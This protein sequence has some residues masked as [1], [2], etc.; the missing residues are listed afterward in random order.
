[1]PRGILIGF[2]QFAEADNCY[3]T[4]DARVYAKETVERLRSSLVRFFDAAG[5]D[6]DV[7]MGELIARAG[8]ESL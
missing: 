1:M 5:A 2:D 4:F 3:V 7:S 8:I 6:A